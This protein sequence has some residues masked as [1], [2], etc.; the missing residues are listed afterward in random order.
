MGNQISYRLNV[1]DN[2]RAYSS[3]ELDGYGLDQCPLCP[4]W[5]PNSV[6]QRNDAMCH[7]RTQCQRSN[8]CDIA[9]IRHSTL[10]KS[11]RYRGECNGA[12]FSGADDGGFQV[13]S[14]ILVDS[15]TH[16]RALQIELHA[17]RSPRPG[18]LR[19][20]ARATRKP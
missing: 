17:V 5:R 19:S 8:R 3:I 2:Q 13:S 4:P 6:S 1:A 7:K 16:R 14:P 12:A 9:P 20:A 11:A 10:R 18:V 15:Q